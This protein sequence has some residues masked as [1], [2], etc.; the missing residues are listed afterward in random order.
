MRT[1]AE[2]MSKLMAMSINAFSNA[3]HDR[4]RRKGLNKSQMQWVDTFTKW[5]VRKQVEHVRSRL[6]SSPAYQE[7][8]KEQ[9]EKRK[10]SE[11]GLV[12]E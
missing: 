9:E 12:V 4:Q 5:I 7:L 11:M 6:D 3:E 1:S 8:L 2:K 10:A